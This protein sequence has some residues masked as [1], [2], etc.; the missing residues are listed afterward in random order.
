MERNVYLKQIP[1]QEALEK[2]FSAL[3]EAGTFKRQVEEI[4]AGEA[5]G[6]V[7]A[8]PVFARISSPHYYAAAMDGIAVR[9]ADTFGASERNP[10]VLAAPA[11]NTGEPLPSGCDAVVMIEDVQPAADGKFELIGAVAPWQNVRPIGEDIVASEMLLPENHQ[12]RPV[13]VG[14]LLAGGVTRLRVWRRPRV[15]LM[16]S[17][18]EIV[19]VL[20][21]QTDLEI[22]RRIDRSSSADTTPASTTLSD[23]DPV[24]PVAGL[25]PGNIIEY[26]SYIIRGLLAEWGAEAEV[27]PIVRDDPELVRA[28]IRDAATR[29]DIVVINAGSSAGSRDY[30]A[31]AVE[32]LG[33]LLV[34]GLAIKPG[35]PAVVG[36]VEGKPVLGI[37]GYP[38]SAVT[39]CELLLKPLVAFYTGRRPPER[40]R[41]NAHLTKR[42][43]SQPGI[44]EFVR[45]R[46]GKVGDRLL[47]SPLSKGAGIVM[48]MVRADG[49]I[50]VPMA[51]QGIPSGGL[52]EVELYRS[53]EEILQTVLLSGS[54]DPIL[55]LLG[56]AMS[57]KY[58]GTSLAVSAVGSL[59]GLLA[60]NRREAHL[61]A[62]NL[63]DEESGEYNLPYVRRY[64]SG[65]SYVVNLAF[66]RQGLIVRPGNP[67]GIRDFADL[68]RPDVAFVNR[69]RGSGTRIWLDIELARRGLAPEQINGYQREE[70]N[71][72]AVAVAVAGGSADAG[73]GLYSAARALG[74]DFVL[75]GE[76]EYDLIIPEEFYELELVQK[77]LATARDADFIALAE[78]LGGYRMSRTGEVIAR[79]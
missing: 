44:E 39:V 69:E 45:V 76:E 13:D 63:L 48:S 1:W 35:K 78:A 62:A 52:A 53:M 50:R 60:I 33:R 37:P 64:V 71:H 58:P 12:I 2:L 17:G 66:R 46:L 47:A 38:V 25:K 65:G 10:V 24:D 72:T 59:G 42:I 27:A 9:A 77:L 73:L 7:T 68:L 20:G 6:R 40:P 75:L 21:R 19:D 49:L 18:S 30:T 4:S 36:V 74:M 57:K 51:S 8:E 70:F 54:H 23:T 16:P 26:N 29:A 32:V 5:F 43:V 15:V 79:L 28:A 67:K 3:R 41:V 31:M 14:A 11:V 22:G 61:A 34:H 55:A 56:N